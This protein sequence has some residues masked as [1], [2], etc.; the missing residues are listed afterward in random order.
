MTHDEGVKWL[1]SIKQDIGQIQCTV[2][3][4]DDDI[5]TQDWFCAYGKRKE[6][7]QE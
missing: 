3:M 1:E 6:G 7:E 4:G 5:H 2:C